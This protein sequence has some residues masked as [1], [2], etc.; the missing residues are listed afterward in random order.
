[1]AR[2]QKHHITYKPVEWMVE[3]NMLLHRGISRVQQTKATPQAYADLTAFAHAVLFEWNRMRM[4]LDSG[5]D[6]RAIDYTKAKLEKKPKVSKKQAKELVEKIKW[7]CNKSPI[8]YEP[9]SLLITLRPMIE[10]GF[11]RKKG[12]AKKNSR[13]QFQNP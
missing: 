1:M 10:E 8:R 5:A 4:E 6:L 2:I 9:E 13:S 3:M 12:N 7:T 11:K